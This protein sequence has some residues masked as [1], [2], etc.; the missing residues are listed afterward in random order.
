MTQRDADTLL[1]G[2]ILCEDGA[3][4]DFAEFGGG[5]V[6]AG[7]GGRFEVVLEGGCFDVLLDAAGDLAGV[8]VAVEALEVEG[9]GGELGGDG[10]VVLFVGFGDV[11]GEGL[12]ELADAGLV[13]SISWILAY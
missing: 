9:D 3:A 10:V 6:V 7:E 13:V 11:L 8:A 5:G 12:L 2:G 1:G 4:A